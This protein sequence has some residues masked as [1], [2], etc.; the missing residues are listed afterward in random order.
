MW[1]LCALQQYDAPALKKLC[2][3]FEVLEFERL[4]YEIKVEEF[5]KLMDIMNALKLESN[6][7][8]INN[9]SL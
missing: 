1:S 7:L 4:A 8:T 6:G 2:K 5:T 9:K 3:A